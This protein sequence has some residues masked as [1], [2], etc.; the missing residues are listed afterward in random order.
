MSRALQRPEIRFLVIFVTI[1]GISF[2]VIA[3]RPVNDNLVVPYTTIVARAS[4]WVL[5]LLGEEITVTGCDLSSPRFAVTI[6]NGCNGLITSLILLSGILAFPAPR[7][8][9]LVGALAGLSIIQ[10]VNLMRIVSLY[11]IGAYLPEL[12]NASHIVVWQSL[13]ILTGVVLWIVWAR[14]ASATRDPDR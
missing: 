10:T 12:F 14:W 4:G 8:A 13:V 11:Y 9:K 1:L 7:R 5:S 6:Y 2:T 3:L